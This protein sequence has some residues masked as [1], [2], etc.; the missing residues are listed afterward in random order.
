M[1]PVNNSVQRTDFKYP[2]K[3]NFILNSSLYRL[4][5]NNASSFVANNYESTF[6][7]S[8]LNSNIVSNFR[9]KGCTL[10]GTF[11]LSGYN[12][13]AR[14]EL[15][16]Y[17]RAYTDGKVVCHVCDVGEMV[18]IDGT[19]IRMQGSPSAH[20]F[21]VLSNSCEKFFNKGSSVF[22]PEE[23]QKII[24]ALRAAAD[25]IL[26]PSALVSSIKSGELTFIPAGWVGHAI[27]IGFCHE[28]MMI[29]NP[30]QGSAD[31]GSPL[32][33]FDIDLDNVTEELISYI[34][35]IRHSNY[36]YSYSFIYNELPQILSPK[37]SEK[38]EPADLFDDESPN[39]DIMSFFADQ[40]PNRYIMSSTDD[41]IYGVL[42]LATVGNCS[43]QAAKCALVIAAIAYQQLHIDEEIPNDRTEGFYVGV[44]ATFSK[45]HNEIYLIFQFTAL[46]QLVNYCDH[47]YSKETGFPKEEMDHLALPREVIKN[48][49][50]NARINKNQIDGKPLSELF[51]WHTRAGEFLDSHPHLAEFLRDC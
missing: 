22:N 24:T 1:I 6:V 21:A 4:V 36:E 47:Y 10:K 2:S 7:K 14:L 41:F 19:Q 17:D 50:K 32:L 45:M 23:Q 42:P 5:W 26:S 31:C 13:I 40:S 16:S 9:D 34:L 27:C 28:Q 38:G 37:F 8:I 35:D 20:M 29:G 11:F 15:S 48:C 46:D 12:K 30:G 39:G 49:W 44:D 43:F 18:T 33:I 25:P 51:R 3:I